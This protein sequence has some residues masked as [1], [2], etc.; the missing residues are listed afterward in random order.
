[1]GT[2]TVGQVHLNACGYPPGGMPPPTLQAP[3]PGVLDTLLLV[4]GSQTQLLADSWLITT[5]IASPGGVHLGFEWALV[6]RNGS[7]VG[8]C[9][10]GGGYSCN[11]CHAHDL[12]N[13]RQFPHIWK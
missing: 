10:G 6:E 7:G 9:P 12:A 5:Q 3:R 4:Q 13:S 11:F 1:M 8:Q 2:S